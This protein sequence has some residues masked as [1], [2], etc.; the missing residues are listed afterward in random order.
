MPHK[1]TNGKWETDVTWRVGA[2]SGRYRET[3]NTRK[4]AQEA[5]DRVRVSL[6]DG[7]F[8]PP[9]ERKLSETISFR[10]FV[11]NKY[12]PWSQVQH[13]EGH[14][15][16]AKGIIDSHLMEEFGNVDLSAIRRA[17]IEAYKLKRAESTYKMPNW[18]NSKQ[19]TPATVNR[20]IACLGSIF[21]LAVDW[22]LLEYSPVT[23]VKQLK[24]EKKPPHLLSKE[25]VHTLLD[26]AEGVRKVV[27]AIAA[28]AGLRRGEIERLQWK[29]I[30]HDTI[31]VRAKKTNDTRKVPLN[32][33]L[34]QIL[35]DNKTL[36]FSGLV[37]VFV[38]QRIAKGV[39]LHQLRHTFCSHCFMAGIDARTIQKWMGHSS[40]NTTLRYAHVSPDHERDSMQR[41][42]YG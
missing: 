40:L 33:V 18:Y 15:R 30:S 7:T 13:S 14:H 35:N 31:T 25:E 32:P 11:M 39:R 12:L 19:T 36:T 21:T 4:A 2:K 28:Y 41:L 10:D 38:P 22:D 24:E 17:D 9:D 8:I 42:N 34:A 29:D 26:Q 20:E 6:A 16:R 27:M 1:T 37:V 5:E 23:K 3:Y